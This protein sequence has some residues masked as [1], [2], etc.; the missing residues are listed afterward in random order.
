M[1]RKTGVFHPTLLE[2]FTKL[3]AYTSD[4]NGIRHGHLGDSYVSLAEARFMLVSCSAF[5]NY[6]LATA[7]E[8]GLE[9]TL[10][11]INKNQTQ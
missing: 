8:A 10:P 9:L 1:E 6:L 5:V 4:A 11:S 2:A 7:T 3:Y